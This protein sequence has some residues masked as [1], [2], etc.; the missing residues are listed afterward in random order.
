MVIFQPDRHLLLR[1]VASHSARFTGEVLDAGGG[2]GRYAS[3]FRHCSYRRLDINASSRPD[4]V[5]SL[6]SLPLQAG[7]LDGIVC[8]QVLG[9]VWNIER[10]IEEC[11]RVLKPGGLFLVTE[12]LFN[13]EHDAPHDYWRLT[14]FAWRKMLE[15][16]FSI[17]ILEPRGG[18]FSQRAQQSIR[19]RIEKYGLYKRPFLGRVAHVWAW[20][21]GH[22]ALRRDAWDTCAANRKFPLGYCI[23]ARKT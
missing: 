23:L 10:A 5:A 16:R 22:I 13:E 11:A 14:Q 3:L 21:I 8:T 12:S 4:I 2:T 17:E 9:D 6:E 20:T 1:F 19:Y 18:Y 15:P 7:S